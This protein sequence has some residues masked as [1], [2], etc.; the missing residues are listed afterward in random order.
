MIL[1]KYLLPWSNQLIQIPYTQAPERKNQYRKI[2]GSLCLKQYQGRCRCKIIYSIIATQ[3]S[4]KN[5]KKYNTNQSTDSYN[6]RRHCMHST[7][8]Y[9]CFV[10]G[11]LTV[12][13]GKEQGREKSVLSRHIFVSTYI[14]IYIRDRRLTCKQRSGDHTALTQTEEY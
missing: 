7:T 3:S 4:L 2:D 8:I 5:I 13:S 11:Q 6:A 12:D 9:F 1:I 14:Y 10:L